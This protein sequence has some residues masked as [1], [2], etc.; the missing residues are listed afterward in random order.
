MI[1][2]LPGNPAGP[3]PNLTM[4]TLSENELMDLN[5]G[6]HLNLLP[7]ITQP[8]VDVPYWMQRDIWE[9]VLGN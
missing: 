2:P 7:R 1:P 5:G 3:K 9:Y 8:L 6:L 4:N